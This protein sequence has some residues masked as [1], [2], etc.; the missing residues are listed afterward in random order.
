MPGDDWQGARGAMPG[1]NRR[2]GSG[3]RREGRDASLCPARGVRRPPPSRGGGAVAVRGRS[4]RRQSQSQRSR[5]VLWLLRRFWTDRSP[6]LRSYVREGGIK[7]RSRVSSV[8]CLETHGR[9]QTEFGQSSAARGGASSSIS[10][11][12]VDRWVGF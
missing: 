10:V 1:A 8:G 9:V 3:V 5:A 11:T 7:I 6:V 4:R 2:R 12:G